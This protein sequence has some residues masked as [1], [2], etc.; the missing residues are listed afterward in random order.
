M[1]AILE[2]N[3]DD[4]DDKLRFEQSSRGPDTI[5]ALCQIREN[6][7]VKYKHADLTDIEYK[8]VAEVNEIIAEVL[9]NLG[10]NLTEL[11]Q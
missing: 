1:K 6:I 4:Y 10:I 8:I 3:L 9:D 11:A 2:F 5:S 7:R